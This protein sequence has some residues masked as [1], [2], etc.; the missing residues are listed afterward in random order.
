MKK[1]TFFLITLFLS[2]ATLSLTAQTTYGDYAG[3]SGGSSCSYFGYKAGQI[4]TGVHNTFLGRESGSANTTGKYNS[5]TGAISGLTNTTGTYNVFQGYYSGANN[6]NGNRNTFIGT[7]SGQSNTA[8]HYNTFLGFRAGFKNKT[9]DRNVMIGYQAGYYETGNNKLYIDNSATTT[10]LIHGDFATDELTV[11]GT[12]NLPQ[13][14]IKSVTGPYNGDKG[15]SFEVATYEHHLKERMIIKANGKVRIGDNSVATPGSFK[16]YVA[17]GIL[18][19]K[20]KVAGITSNDWAD[21]VFDEEYDLNSIE[22]VESFIKTNKH[23]PNVP[24]AK[25]VSEN[26]VEMVKMDATLLRQ[27]EELWLHVIELKKENEALK[28][29]VERMDAGK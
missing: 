11:N 21:F 7:G 19:E 6:K 16:L 8:G 22:K 1:I 23:L 12:V 29:K 25:E 15:I 5:F 4:S 2:I 18:S 20:V 14:T 24:S 26:G 3:T 28:A 9:G 27:I 17:E 10:P 13:P